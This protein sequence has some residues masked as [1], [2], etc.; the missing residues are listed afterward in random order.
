MNQQELDELDLAFGSMAEQAAKEEA[1]RASRKGQGGSFTYEQVKWTGLETGTMKVVRCL[2]AGPDLGMIEGKKPATPFD[3]RV[4]RM[5]RIIDDKGKQMKLVLPRRANDPNHILWRIIDRVNEVDWVPDPEGKP[6][7]SDPS[8]VRNLK[9]F[10]N[11]RRHPDLFNIVNFSN[12]SESD[13]K[14]KF[15]LMG[16]GWEGREV[17]IMNVLDRAMINWHRENKHSALLAKNVTIS[18]KDDGKVMEFVDE[19]IPAYGFTELLNAL[20][21]TYKY[22]G[23]YDIGII[24]TGQASPAYKVFN[25]SRT[26]EVAPKDLQ[27]LIVMTP[28]SDEE[29]GWERYDLDKMF[30][31]TS[32]TKLWNRLH[33]TIS[34]IDAKMGTSYSVEL[35]KLADQEATERAAKKIEEAEEDDE[36]QEPEVEQTEVTQRPARTVVAP[37]SSKAGSLGPEFLLGW[38]VM[39]AVE[40]ASVMEVITLGTATTPS[41][42]KYIPSYKKMAECSEC[43]T[44]SPLEFTHCPGCGFAFPTF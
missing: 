13:P 25:L 32:F 1:D 21:T 7:Q 4:V 34:M 8:K 15:G 16:K 31:V 6:S 11:E 38:P 17:L 22:W 43:H 37:E 39:T 40:Q 28:T 33:L 29:E 9:V 30:G 12:L 42:L 5:A 26:P 14:R 44:K 35:K 3:A 23:K 36:V 2:G 19:G 18:K 10:V 27:S 24:R 20:L 41:V